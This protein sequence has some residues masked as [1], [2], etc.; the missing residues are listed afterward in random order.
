MNMII[1]G[2]G[3]NNIEQMDA[4]EYPIKDKYDVVLSNY[5]FSQ[6]T[7]YSGL[8]GFVTSDANPYIFETYL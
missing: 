2:D 8:Y 6:K 4:L 1:I 3:H 5:A 7:D